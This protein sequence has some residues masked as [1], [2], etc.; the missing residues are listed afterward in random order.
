[1][2][3]IEHTL[4]AQTD[5]TPAFARSLERLQNGKFVV[6]LT[7]SGWWRRYQ[8]LYEG[9]TLTQ[10]NAILSLYNNGADNTFTF[11][12]GSD[13]ITAW[14]LG[15]PQKQWFPGDKYNVF[16]SAQQQRYAGSGSAS[17]S[18][19]ESQPESRVVWED[20][21]VTASSISGV[22]DVANQY[23]AKNV[24]YLEWI[25]PPWT[26][27]EFNTFLNVFNSNQI[28]EFDVVWP[29][30]NRTYQVWFGETPF[31]VARIGEHYVLTIQLEIRGR[32]SDNFWT[33]NAGDPLT[34]NGGDNLVT[35]F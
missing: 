18:L 32:I 15:K 17:W 27:S 25:T 3:D 1:M 7:G 30:D 20:G 10:Y 14:F 19:T 29:E 12:D 21:I 9:L 13:T 4:S 34:I 11:L 24:G 28:N 26:Q 23:G 33:T 5:M 2:A 22:T 31:T 16:F 35:N 8:L 6:R